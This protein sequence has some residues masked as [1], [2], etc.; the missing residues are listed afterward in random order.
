MIPI[1]DGLA[2]EFEGRITVLQLDA[3]LPE[4]E[5]LQASY[6]LRGHPTFL[7]LDQ[8]GN[9]IAQ[10]IGPQTTETLRIALAEVTQ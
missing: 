5:Q 6:G 4:N 7:V 2:S 1:V 9:V 3:G 8:E 10:F